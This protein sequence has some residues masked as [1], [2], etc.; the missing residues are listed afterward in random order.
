MQSSNFFEPVPAPHKTKRFWVFVALAIVPFL[1]AP[2][3]MVLLGF[4][5]FPPLRIQ[6]WTALITLVAWAAFFWFTFRFGRI[7]WFV[8][9]M[10]MFGFAFLARFYLG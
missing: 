5:R 2:L 10:L 8:V 4:H 9:A 1:C 6:I 3:C 7:A